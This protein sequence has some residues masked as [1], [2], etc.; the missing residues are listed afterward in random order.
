MKIKSID[1]DQVKDLEATMA[2]LSAFSLLLQL[3]HN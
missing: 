2:L 1:V 3:F